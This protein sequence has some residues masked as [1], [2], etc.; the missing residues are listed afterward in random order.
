M[1]FDVISNEL[2]FTEFEQLF[3]AYVNLKYSEVKS[4]RD[5]SKTAFKDESLRRAFEQQEIAKA[6][7][8]EQYAAQYDPIKPR[9]LGAFTQ[10]LVRANLKHLHVMQE[11]QGDGLQRD[12]FPYQPD[13]LM[14]HGGQKVGVFVLKADESMRDTHEPDGFVA[15]KMRL[16]ASAHSLAGKSG[17]S[18]MK[19]VP[20]AISAVVDANL[21]EYKMNLREDFDIGKYL[22]EQ[23][24]A[25]NPNGT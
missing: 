7:Y 4:L 21:A 24:L 10:S 16:I 15:G 6:T 3:D 13:V 17:N 18:V 22:K 9:V 25:D 8:D 19:G 12:M 20:L 1:N 11:G 5:L 23:G 14:S 2:T